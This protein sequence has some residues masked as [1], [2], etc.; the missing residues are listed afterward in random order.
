MAS[1]NKNDCDGKAKNNRC[2]ER[3]ADGGAVA[4]HGVSSELGASTGVVVRLPWP[5]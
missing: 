1:H 4:V 2:E 3:K 5:Y